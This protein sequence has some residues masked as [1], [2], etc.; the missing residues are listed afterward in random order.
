M[1]ARNELTTLSS[2]TR[3]QFICTVAENLLKGR[4]SAP[5]GRV[6]LYAVQLLQV[7]EQAKAEQTNR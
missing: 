7:E 2:G 5:T 1:V 6:L 3:E 4:I